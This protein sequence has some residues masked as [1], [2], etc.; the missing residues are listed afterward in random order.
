MPDNQTTSLRIVFM[1]TPDFAV[2][3]LE[4][5]HQDG[6]SILSVVTAP[7]RP[8]GRG[9]KLTES[10]VKKWAVAHGL[11]VLQPEKLKSPDFE[12]ALKELNADLFVVVAFRMLPE[13]IW[14]MPP[15][16]T[17]NLHGSLLPRYRGAAPI[18]RA[19]MNGE[20]KTGVTTFFL[21]R[22]IDT[23]RIILQRSLNIGPDETAGELHDR[24][25]MVGADCLAETVR[26]IA[27]NEAPAVEQQSL[28]NEGIE[29][30]HA[31]KIFREDC[32][33]D[34]GQSVDVVHNLVRG[35]SPY[36]CAWTMLE[37]KILKIYRG[38]KIHADTDLIPGQWETDG[39][40]YLRF[41]CADGWYHALEVQLEGKKAM[42][43]AGFLRGWKS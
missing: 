27:R 39:A 21:Q 15:L 8:A 12:N 30:I 1:G 25:M 9:L 2:P 29:V 13:I 42:D 6:H 26:M 28:I 33:I 5:L 7:D 14:T 38:K 40:E 43:I 34:W 17:I 19:I 37:G 3:S 16:G 24:M 11:P 31:P 23:G 32:E 20:S 10:A 36:P 22:E 35:L 4:A 41:A 18:N